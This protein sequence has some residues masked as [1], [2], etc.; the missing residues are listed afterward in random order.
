MR[1]FDFHEPASVAEACHMLA[2]YGDDARLI[3]GGTALVLALRQRLL[4]P[5]H[6]VSLGRI[7][8]L[9]GIGWHETQGLRIGALTAHA[10]VA[11][12]P[13]VKARYPMLADM[14]AR[15]ANPQV[16]HQGTIGGNLC[17]ADPATDPPGCLLAL[18]AEV[19]VVGRGGE[20]VLKIE[21]FIVDYYTTALE[22]DEVLTEIRLPPPA[23]DADGRYVRHLRTAA[24]HRPLVNLSVLVRRSGRQCA[25]A[26]LVLGA[27]TTIPTRLAQAEACLQGRAITAD[28]AAEAAQCGAAEMAPIDDSRG[29][30]AYRR[31]ITAVVLRR[32]LFDLFDLH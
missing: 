7:D 18:G 2:D 27:S 17:Y 6:L 5:A 21:D 16:R 8:S 23:A 12:S 22:A 19:V 11:A 9:R 24:E 32:T 1:E 20:R 4:T 3:A 31:D 26:R 25:Q 15:M 10:E 14:A 30:A 13:L 28:V 29:S